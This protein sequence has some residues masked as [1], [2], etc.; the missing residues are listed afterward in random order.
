MLLLGIVYTSFGFLDSLKG[1][2]SLTTAYIV[3]LRIFQGIASSTMQTTY[4]AMGTNDF[5]HR[6]KIIVG[7]IEVVTGLGC[8]IGP[9]IGAALIKPF[10]FTWSFIIVGLTI[11]TFSLFF[12]C[13]FPKPTIQEDDYVEVDELGEYKSDIETSEPEVNIEVA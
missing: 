10:G 7:G 9:L 13:L 6:S 4:Y 3:M 8:I 12:F 5:P 11:V 2:T 1:N